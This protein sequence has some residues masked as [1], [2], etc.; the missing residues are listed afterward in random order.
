MNEEEFFPEIP[1]IPEVPEQYFEKGL[2]ESQLPDFK[3]TP[4]PP[5]PAQSAEE[6]G[7]N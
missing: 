5:P 1:E 4:P 7:S 2:N 3:L 6:S